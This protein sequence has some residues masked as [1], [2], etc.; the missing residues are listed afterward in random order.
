MTKRKP[1]GKPPKFS[2]KNLAD[3]STQQD[4]R[5]CRQK[6]GRK[7]QTES[8]REIQEKII[9]EKRGSRKMELEKEFVGLG[10]MFRNSKIKQAQLIFCLY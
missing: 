6:M 10:I 4:N 3:S 7:G 5:D 8:I 1:A 2:K 9:E